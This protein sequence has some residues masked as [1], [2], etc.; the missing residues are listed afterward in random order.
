[1]HIRFAALLLLNFISASIAAKTKEIGILRAVGARGADVFRIFFSEAFIFAMICFVLSSIGA[2]ILCNVINNSVTE[3][4]IIP[5]AALL[6][7]NVLNVGITLL[8][9]LFVSAIATFI[10]VFN[11]ARK[12]PVDS[13]RTL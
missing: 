4:A 2:G 1:M 11:A 10:P 12:S 6:N 5:T 13:I 8:I 7:F 3:S 9:S